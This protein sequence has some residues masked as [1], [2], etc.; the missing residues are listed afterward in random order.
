M[1]N[2]TVTVS[3]TL[4]CALICTA[5][6]RAAEKAAEKAVSKAAAPTAAA[7]VD[8]AAKPAEK[9]PVPAKELSK[10]ELV[11]RLN[12]KAQHNPDLPSAVQGLAI[13]EAD[14]KKYIE[15][16]GKK[17]EDI[18]KET[19]L[20]LYISVSRYLTIRNTERIQK[21]LRSIKQIEDINRAQRNIAGPGVPV[22]PKIPQAPPRAQ[23]PPR[24][25]TVPTTYK[26]PGK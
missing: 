10:E 18:D 17:L 2:I 4:M 20:K 9:K 19:L 11:K 14:G 3:I 8:K 1:K 7:A 24:A 21:Q 23:T 6:A 25:P 26:T 5:G 22:V 16:N 13:K 15:F 12:E